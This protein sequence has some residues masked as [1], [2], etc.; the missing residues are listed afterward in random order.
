MALPDGGAPAFYEP[1][2]ERARPHLERI[3]KQLP[4]FPSPPLRVQ[5]VGQLDA[6]LLDQELTDLLAEPLKA[7]LQKMNPILA[8]Q[9]HAELYLLLRL[10][11]YKFS[12]YDRSASYGAMLQNLKYRNEWVHR[13]HCT[14]SL[15]T[16]CPPRHATPRSPLSSLDYTH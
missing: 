6:D 10:L 7:A 2:W 14:F 9:R 8:K 3:R 11:L 13:A 12:I 15:L 5:R 1:A 4:Y 16:Q